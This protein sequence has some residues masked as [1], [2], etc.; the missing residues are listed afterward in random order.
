MENLN[1]EIIIDLTVGKE[2]LNESYLAQFGTAI[3]LIL[4]RMFGLNDLGFKLRGPTSS[5]DKFIRTLEKEREYARTFRR[6]GLDNPSVLNNKWQLDKA[7]GEFE[8][9]TGIKWP[10]K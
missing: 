8:K 3:E 4:Q 5:V 2:Q 9:A 1:K 7:V 10:L 6:L